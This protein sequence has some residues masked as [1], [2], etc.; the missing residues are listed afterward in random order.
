MWVTK[1]GTKVIFSADDGT[2][3]RELWI[4]DSTNSGTFMIKDINPGNNSSNPTGPM[5]EMNGFI[6]FSANDGVHGY[7]LWRTDGTEAGTTMVKDVRQGE[8]SSLDWGI[9]RPLAW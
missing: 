2:N 6:Y 1:L 3:G 8:N 4:S 9:Y 7:E 5:K